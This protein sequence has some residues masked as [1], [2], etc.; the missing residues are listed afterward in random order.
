MGEWE[1]W[2]HRSQSKRVLAPSGA[3]KKIRELTFFFFFNIW[4]HGENVWQGRRQPLFLPALHTFLLLLITKFPFSF[5]ELSPIAWSHVRTV[6]LGSLFFLGQRV[7][8]WLNPCP[9]DS[10]LLDFEF[11]VDCL[12]KNSYVGNTLRCFCL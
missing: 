4:Q 5:R 9:S 1:E 8:M 2:F 7:D 11:W 10:V 3:I 6:S 12:V